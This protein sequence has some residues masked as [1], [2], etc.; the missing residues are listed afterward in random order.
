MD[1]MDQNLSKL[2][3]EEE[4]LVRKERF[5]YQELLD[6]VRQVSKLEDVS[7]LSR[8]RR[9]LIRFYKNEKERWIP[10]RGTVSEEQ[11]DI[12]EYN[13]G[14][15][16][17]IQEQGWEYLIFS[18]DLFYD[19]NKS[20]TKEGNTCR[21]KD[22]ACRLQENL[23]G[24]YWEIN[25]LDRSNIIKCEYYQNYYGNQYM[26]PIEG[27][28]SMLIKMTNLEKWKIYLP[29][30]FFVEGK[31]GEKVVRC[32]LNKYE[33]KPSFTEEEKNFFFED[34]IRTNPEDLDDIKRIFSR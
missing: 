20:S 5:Q 17:Y 29:S 4:S 34:V 19:F 10:S 31:E 25:N 26:N 2:R 1:A 15:L 27:M 14:Y 28:P 18:R 16:Y 21:L 24:Y 30:S 32:R 7:I 23:N 11:I 22:A 8:G 33:E 13:G 6:W 9:H 3:E 12:V